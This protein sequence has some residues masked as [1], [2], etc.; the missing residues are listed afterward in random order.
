M[1]QAILLGTQRVGTNMLGS[2]FMSHPGIVAFPEVFKDT[3]SADNPFP[4]RIPNYRKFAF[5]RIRQGV[6]LA[7]PEYR[8]VLINDYFDMLEAE[9]RP[10]TPVQVIGVKYNSLHHADG[11]WRAPSDPP[12][13]LKVFRNRGMP[14]IHVI[15]EDLVATAYSEL[16]AQSSQTYITRVPRVVEPHRFRVEPADFLHRLRRIRDDRSM[17]ER[18]LAR[19]GLKVLVLQYEHL[20]VEE[21]ASDIRGSSIELIAEFLDLDPDGFDPA[22]KTRKISPVSFSDELENF[23]EIEKA[24][25]GTE[26]H[27]WFIRHA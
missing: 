10:P 12:D 18:W 7:L 1:S 23:D 5:D 11:Y 2:L 4:E 8:T 21:P 19:T 27:A 9:T 16:R 15:R 22:P 14:I 24:V 17:V 6:E 3:V 13:M 20:F 26:F 25:R